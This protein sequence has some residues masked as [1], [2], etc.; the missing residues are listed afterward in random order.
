MY[1]SKL[2]ID[3]NLETPNV[4][5]KHFFFKNVQF[6]LNKFK[7]IDELSNLEDEK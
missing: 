3:F 5:Q 7:I 4:R 1:S 2:R 6:H